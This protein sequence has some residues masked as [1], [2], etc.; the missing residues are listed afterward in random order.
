MRFQILAPEGWKQEF[1]FVALRYDEMERPAEE[2][3]AEQYQ[4]FANGPVTY[5]VFVTNFVEEP[6]DNALS[7]SC[8]GG[9][10][11]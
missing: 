8:A 6:I 10:P 2:S 3:P 7:N 5:R 1:R 4:L 11:D 9:E